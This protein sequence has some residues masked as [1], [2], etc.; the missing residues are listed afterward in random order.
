MMSLN[1]QSILFRLTFSYFLVNLTIAACGEGCLRCNHLVDQCEVCD[2]IQGYFDD[3]KGGC[4]KVTI[5]NCV[6]INSEGKCEY[7]SSQF[8][9][10]TLSGDCGELNSNEVIADC[11][12]Y[13]ADANCIVCIDGFYLKNGACRQVLVPIPDCILYQAERPEICVRCSKNKILNKDGTSCE[14]VSADDNCISYNY[15]DC[16]DCVDDY[17]YEPNAYIT[18]LISKSS[19]IYGFL[20]DIQNQSHNSKIGEFCLPETIK[21]CSQFMYNSMC[22]ECRDGYFRTDSGECILSPD[23]PLRNCLNY[24]GEGLCEKCISGYY[25]ENN[26]CKVITQ[27]PDCFLYEVESDNCAQCNNVTYL[28]PNKTCNPRSNSL[29]DSNCKIFEIDQDRCNTCRS[30]YVPD[31]N[32]VC[33]E[34][35]SDCAEYSGTAGN[36][37]CDQCIDTYFYNQTQNWC[38]QPLDFAT[39]PC[40]KY[41]NS[42]N[43]CRECKEGF[44]MDTTCQP[45]SNLDE[46]C[47]ESSK[48]TPN[49]CSKCQSG[50][51]LFDNVKVCA[52]VATSNPNCLKWRSSTECDE[53]IPN[54]QAPNCTLIPINEN[55]SFKIEG[56]NICSQCRDGFFQNTAT[57]NQ[58][59]T[60]L[61]F[62]KVNCQ[63]FSLENGNDI[64]RCDSCVKGAFYMEILNF[65]GCMKRTNYSSFANCDM[66]NYDDG[67][68][69]NTCIKCKMDKVLNA[70][71]CDDACPADKIKGRT[72]ISVDT[73]DNDRLGISALNT[74]E[75]VADVSPDNCEIVVPA[76]DTET[77]TFICAKCKD[78][79]ERVY[80]L[81]TLNK[82][83]NYNFDEDHYDDIINRQATF[84]CKV[85]DMVTDF[86]TTNC[87]VY[88]ETAAGKHG[89]LRCKFGYTGY[90]KKADE[91]EDVYF[92]KEC[93]SLGECNPAD[94]NL[95]GITTPKSLTKWKIPLET[96]ISCLVCTG[97]DMM[98][99]VIVRQETDKALSPIW[100]NILNF[101][102]SEIPNTNV[103]DTNSFGVISNCLTTSVG[104]QYGYAEDF[105][106]TYPEFCVFLLY[107]IDQNPNEDLTGNNPTVYCVACDRGYRIQER[108]ALAEDIDVVRKC[109]LIENCNQSTWFNYC[110]ICNEGF[111]YRYD[112]TTKIIEYDYCVAAPEGESNCFATIENGECTVCERG[113]SKNDEGFCED[114][115]FAN[116]KAS[117]YLS[118]NQLFQGKITALSIFDF[119]SVLYFHGKSNIGSSRYGCSQCDGDYIGVKGLNSFGHCVQSSYIQKGQ[120]NELKFIKNCL[121]FGWDYVNLKHVCRQCIP[122]YMPNFTGTKCVEKLNYCLRAS[123]NGEKFCEICQEGFTLINNNCVQNDITNCIEFGVEQNALICLKCSNEYY[124]Y[125]KKFCLQG[126]VENCYQYFENQPGKC[127]QCKDE[128][129]IFNIQTGDSLCVPFFNQNCNKWNSASTNGNFECSE[130]KENYFIDD[131]S[132]GYKSTLCFGPLNI[133]NCSDVSVNISSGNDLT[134][135]CETCE[136]QYFKYNSGTACLVL[137]SVDY[138]S[139]YST[140]DNRCLSCENNYYLDYTGKI[141]HQYP[142]GIFGCEIYRSLDECF[143]CRSNMY[144]FDNVCNIID[145]PDWIE[146]CEYYSTLELCMKCESGYILEKNVCKESN[147]INCLT[148]ENVNTCETCPS[149]YGLMV[150]DKIT[151][152]VL[153]NIPNCEKTTQIHPFKCI[154]CN[155]GYYQSDGGCFPSDKI[156]NCEYYLANKVCLSCKDGF[157]KSLDGLSCSSSDSLNFP[158]DSKCKNGFLSPKRI[159]VA[160]GPGYFLSENLCKPC[161]TE[162][163]CLFC[164]PSNSKECMVCSP[165][166]IMLSSGKCEGTPISGFERVIVSAEDGNSGTDSE[167]EG[168]LTILSLLFFYVLFHQ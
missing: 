90:V 13:D 116:C 60:G 125:N 23:E 53:C 43:E 104:A 50:Y 155:K 39:S 72:T 18:D 47:I 2:Y 20:L 65:W 107:R 16:S 48:T 163:N 140:D 118:R 77:N 95:L 97:K 145:P 100:Y 167:F 57:S 9:P 79:F 68:G 11:L 29:N 66:I 34:G 26:Q 141:C 41:G 46:N 30:G 70:G 162:S 131:Y 44:Y 166:T 5:D 111:V 157:V 78:G 3:R 32:G 146:N 84:S 136:N 74:C 58:C 105:K 121:Q 135:Q 147:A 38:E 89:C 134:Y 1:Y 56:S 112:T 91:T 129:A 168:K 45:H 124:L 143:Q 75:T 161:Q 158:M 133:E 55:C 14:D 36:L 106:V 40:L 93:V 154:I 69:T 33:A 71:S 8:K 88:G 120:F 10:R 123:A 165:G 103:T 96:F 80:D 101:V 73:A 86:L 17:F 156:V 25:L 132:S 19:Q 94:S 7:C 114:F 150:V 151:N 49:Q 28:L 117:T 160:C 82:T 137:D 102:T 62:E 149:G 67:A 35:I 63:D 87:D 27:V 127:E 37:T 59:I 12:H 152:C 130:C 126:R 42:K 164:N 64:V 138:C 52:P 139:E 113:F 122:G 61:D 148:Y 153:I 51:G 21:N 31:N 128:Y 108:G 22:F 76:V 98:P 6:Y 144:L 159:C 99:V 4:D 15:Y 24:K 109:E 81:S 54:Y 115:N 142:N 83:F 119:T 110:S 85:L 92:I